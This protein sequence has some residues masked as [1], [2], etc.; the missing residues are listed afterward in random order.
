MNFVSSQEYAI[1]KTEN[2]S[3]INEIRHIQ[4]TETS[5]G[6]MAIRS[7]DSHYDDIT[8]ATMTS[9]F[10][11]RHEKLTHPSRSNPSTSQQSNTNPFESEANI[12]AKRLRKLSQTKGSEKGFL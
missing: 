9:A 5:Q 2:D 12:F 1:L 11:I 8:N 6:N 10:I 7:K 3:L 4:L